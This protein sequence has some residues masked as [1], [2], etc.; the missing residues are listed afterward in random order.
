VRRAKRIAFA[1]FLC[2]AGYLLVRA[3]QSVDWHAVF[4]ALRALDAAT[5]AG[6]FALTAASYLLYTGYDLAARG[7]AHH[8]VR[9]PRVM[10]IAF[11][12]YA[13]AL[14]IGALVGGAGFRLR[15]YA[16]EGVALAAITR[17]IAF[18]VATNWIGYVVL[19]GALFA[20][21]AVVPSASFPLHVAGLGMAAGMRVIG[22]VLLAV[23]V[24]YLIACRVTHGRIFH[25]RGHHFRLPSVRLALLQIAMAAT[26]WTLMGL[27]VARFL[28][29]VGEA[30]VL[31]AL[32]L[33]AVATAVAHIPAGIGVLEA[34]FIA[35]LGHRV[36]AAQIIAALLAYRACYYLAP[37]AVA[38]VVYAGLELQRPSSTS[39]SVARQ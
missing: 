25:V 34:V 30:V 2:A 16:R 26:N 19:A 32:L 6:A 29:H 33:A 28:P 20:S 38:T 15:M 5:L 10:A 24:A 8:H 3:A 22:L 14:N 36:P 7:Y 37:L 12:A 1:G 17:V 27:V 39:P 35:A 21:G 18:C 11:V 31:G 9:T 13:F 23:A 4:D